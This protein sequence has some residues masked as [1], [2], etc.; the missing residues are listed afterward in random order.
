MRVSLGG[1]DSRPEPTADDAPRCV[2][3][4]DSY[5][6]DGAPVPRVSTILDATGSATAF[7]GVPQHI[8]EAAMLKGTHIHEACRLAELGRLDWD[9]C[10]PL[11]ARHAERWLE[12]L[13]ADKLAIVDQEVM[14]YH[15]DMLYAGTLDR[16]AQ[17]RSHDGLIVLEIK[18]G[19]RYPNHRL[20]TAAYTM[21][22][23]YRAD[24]D[25][26]LGFAYRIACYVS[27]TGVEVECHDDQSDYDAWAAAVTLYHWRNAR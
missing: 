7:A 17:R 26:R 2:R 13:E 19:R 4:G 20:Q 25:T 5:S 12:W 16:I 14:V 3:L 11:Y 10:D 15:P 23:L 1:M 22:G 24:R 6:I 8:R 18:T 9:N 21:D 27:E